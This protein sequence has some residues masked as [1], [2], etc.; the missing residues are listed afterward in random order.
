[1]IRLRNWSL[2]IACGVL[3]LLMWDNTLMDS[4]AVR[5]I[6]TA[7]LGCA[8][9][10]AVMSSRWLNQ[11]VHNDNRRHAFAER[12]GP[13]LIEAVLPATDAV[14]FQLPGL[15]PQ[16]LETG[17]E[18]KRY[19]TFTRRCY[20]GKLEYAILTNPLQ[21]GSYYVRS[22]DDI[23]RLSKAQVEEWV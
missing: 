3:G 7:T 9:S 23:V 13:Y 20:D 16:I 17:S 21:V 4:R 14:I 5:I 12:R 8:F 2:L 10:S 11:T 19:V 1:M 22:D 6:G 18:A 15:E